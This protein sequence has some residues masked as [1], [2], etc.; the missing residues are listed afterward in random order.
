VRGSPERGD[1][2]LE[3]IEAELCQ[4]DLEASGLIRAAD[5]PVFSQSPITG[6]APTRVRLIV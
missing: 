5:P 4:S 1:L 6:L 2:L 3:R